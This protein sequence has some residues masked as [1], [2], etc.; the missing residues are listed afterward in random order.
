VAPSS[1]RPVRE[2][3]AGKQSV[4]PHPLRSQ[5]VGHRLGQHREPGPQAVAGRQSGHRPLDTGRQHQGDR[6]ALGR[7]RRHHRSADPHRAQEDAVEGASP[8]DVGQPQR[9]TRR[10]AS[11]ADQRA[12]HPAVRLDRGSHQAVR[13]LGIGQVRGDADRHGPGAA[14]LTR[15]AEPLGRGLHRAG[16]PRGQD[17]AGAVRDERGG[18]GQTEPA[19]R[20]GDEEDLAAQPEIHAST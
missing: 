1:R 20:T 15:T 10:R 6:P 5:L 7:E 4:D 3:L 17:D 11:D 14:S 8:L 13:R 12:V 19:R 2:H 18:G 9:R 16:V